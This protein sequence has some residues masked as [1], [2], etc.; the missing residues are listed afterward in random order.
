MARARTLQRRAGSIWLRGSCSRWAARWPASAAARAAAPS[1]R[2]ARNADA[3]AEAPLAYCGT[4]AVP[5]DHS[6]P[7]GPQISIAYRWYPATR[8]GEA[9]PRGT[10]VPVEGGPGYPSIESVSYRSL[11]RE[12]RLQRDVR[13]AAAALE[14]AR[15]R[16]SR[17][18]RIDAAVTARRC[19][20]SPA[21]RASEAF[22]QAAAPAQKR[23]TTAGG[24]PNG[25]W[26]HAS[27]MFSSAPAAEDLAA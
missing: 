14:H 24:T 20:T 26:V 15:R 9:A 4:L 27:D 17:H 12:H 1:L 6:A 13:V 5:L 10:V 23:S 16:Q 2:S 18:G 19:R 21:R 3:C 8:G 22:Q 11:G 7:A 25:S